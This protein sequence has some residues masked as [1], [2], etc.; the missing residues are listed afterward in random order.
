MSLER[1]T[2]EGIYPAAVPGGGADGTAQTDNGRIQ[3]AT[4]EAIPPLVERERQEAHLMNML[5]ATILVLGEQADATLVENLVNSADYGNFQGIADLFHSQPDEVRRQI[6]QKV[7]HVRAVNHYVALGIIQGY[8]G[9]APFRLA[10]GVKDGLKS[11]E[12]TVHEVRMGLLLNGRVETPFPVPNGASLAN[13]VAQ[14]ESRLTLSDLD[15]QEI[16]DLELEL[17]YNVPNLQELLSRLGRRGK[18]TQGSKR[19]PLLTAEDRLNRKI[20]LV[21]K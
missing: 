6:A 19:E 17:A 2:I 20:E 9:G 7:E 8:W 1:L 12:D 14:L 4:G 15:H 13:A 21:F 3:I 18:G 5:T 11:A 16:H 10:K